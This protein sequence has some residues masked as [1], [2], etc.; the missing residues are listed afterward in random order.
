ML[1]QL[2]GY[3]QKL[4]LALNGMHAPLFDF[5]MYWLSNKLIWIPLYVWLLYHM[6]ILN[7][8]NS[9]LIIL[10]VALLITLTDQVSVQLFK[11][12]FQRLRPCHEPALEGLVRILN[13]HCG[14][15]YGFVSSHACNT[16]GVAVFSGMLLRNRF[17]WLLPAMI[18][19]SLLIS[20]SRIYL[21]VH[22]PG[23]VVAGF[24]VGAIIGFLIYRLFKL[25]DSSIR[26]RKA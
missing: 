8:A 9:W 1:E 20:Y 4:F 22:Y 21:G 2:I 6:L 23:D 13:G 19:W 10:S 24:L 5:I 12:T 16:A 17:R 3:D 26:A 15:S 25:V 7:R 11:E 18:S 14:G